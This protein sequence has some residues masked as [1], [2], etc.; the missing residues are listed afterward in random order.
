MLNLV[1]IRNRQTVTSS[2]TV[3]EIFEKEHFHVLRD[4]R[5]LIAGIQSINARIQNRID[6]DTCA[7]NWIYENV[8]KYFIE[9]FYTERGIK[10]TEY[11][12]TRDGFV[13]LAMGFTGK[14]ALQ[15]KIAYI[16][17]FDAME[18]ELQNL[19]SE[20]F[21]QID[22]EENRI[23]RA[24]EFAEKLSKK[25]LW[26]SG[27]EEIAKMQAVEIS[28]RK[29]NLDMNLFSFILSKSTE[30]EVLYVTE[31]ARILGIEANDVNQILRRM[32]FQ[33]R[34]RKI[35]IP[36]GEG[37]KFAI[38]NPYTKWK[39]AVIEPI[40]KFLQERFDE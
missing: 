5:N 8:S 30:S 31:I 35:W 4:I 19:R 26:I 20:Q 14:K 10:K 40:K 13:L 2:R 12:M 11:F 1:H 23:I 16:K 27:S 32:K 38:A 15:F 3:A 21:V 22:N 29:F 33:R 6:L 17:A 36:I 24:I 9:S 7:Q 28:A 37:L 39:A 18:E 34:F 25:L